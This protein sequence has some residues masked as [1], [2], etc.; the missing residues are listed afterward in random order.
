MDSYYGISTTDLN[1]AAQTLRVGTGITSRLQTVDTSNFIS[2]AERWAEA[3]I[4][5]FVA[6]PLKPTPIR[7]ESSVPTTPTSENYPID[8]IEAIIYHAVSRI[9]SSEFF[10]NEPN[11]STAAEYA[12]KTAQQHAAN[13][14]SR[15][16]TLV[17]GGRRRNP[18]PMVPPNMTAFR[19]ET[20]RMSQ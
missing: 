20:P 9:L 16:T 1:R 12:E 19:D 13:M 8:F 6:V 18:N 5:E 10:A 17:G 11:A 2:K 14:V 7:G 4:S 15:T 3:A